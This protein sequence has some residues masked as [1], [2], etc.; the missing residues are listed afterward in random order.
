[1]VCLLLIAIIILQCQCQCQWEW[2]YY[3]LKGAFLLGD[4]LLLRVQTN[5]KNFPKLKR[6]KKLCVFKMCLVA[7][8]ISIL[9]NEILIRL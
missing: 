7:Y 5:N 3:L 2:D 4:Q 1:M 8:V 6:C 9:Y